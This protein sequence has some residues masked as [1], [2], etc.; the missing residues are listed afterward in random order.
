MY[1]PE[2]TS[3]VV[4]RKLQNDLI[5]QVFEASC[6]LFLICNLLLNSLWEPSLWGLVVVVRRRLAL[7]RNTMISS[8]ESPN[9]TSLG[10]R[11]KPLAIFDGVWPSFGRDCSTEKR[12]ALSPQSWQGKF[13]PF[14]LKIYIIV[15]INGTVVRGILLYEWTTKVGIKIHFSYICL[16]YEREFSCEW[17]TMYGINTVPIIDNILYSVIYQG[18]L[19]V[20]E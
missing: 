18:H 20:L 4:E 1:L 2:S 10:L 17:N 8:S 7:G 13:N 12:W 19:H 14:R 16:L 15:S 9:G 11:R 3:N 5:S 6:N